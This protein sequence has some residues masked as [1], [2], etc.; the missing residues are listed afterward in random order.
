MKFRS[1][2]YIFQPHSKSHKFIYLFFKQYFDFKKISKE[3]INLI[4]FF[5]KN[6]VIPLL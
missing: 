4:V 3:K 5:K 1:L 6:I 2:F